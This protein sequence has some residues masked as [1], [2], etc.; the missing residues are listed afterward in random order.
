MGSQ[1]GDD[2]QLNG[3]LACENAEI[4]GELIVAGTP[5]TPGAVADGNYGDVTVSVGGT[6]WT[7]NNGVV[8]LAKMAN[9]AQATVIGRASGAGTGAPTALSQAQLTSL[10]TSMLLAQLAPMGQATIVGRIAG[11]GTGTPTALTATQTG[12]VLSGFGGL[13][14]NVQRFTA[15]GTY[16]PTA[17]T[18]RVIAILQGGGG[19]GAGGSQ[20]ATNASAGG[21]GGSG[22]TLVVFMPDSGSNLT[23]GAVV[24]GAGGAAPAAGLNAGNDGA[25]STIVLNGA[26]QQAGFG[27]GGNAGINSST[28]RPGG[29]GGDLGSAN[30]SSGPAIVLLDSR[31]RPGYAGQVYSGALGG[32][33]GNGGDPVFGQGGR[34]AYAVGGII[35]GSQG[36][37]G[38]GG[39]GGATIAAGADAAGGAG[40][41]GYVAVL[42]FS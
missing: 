18:R 41:S 36:F 17:N 22:G 7:I 37:F 31:A 12:Q 19:S 9:L 40:G 11:G 4:R 29:L 26:T 23:G 42:E 1:Q 34:G 3:D 15:N 39:G 30:A 25:I 13:L 24:V 33:A 20:T 32:V 6:V 5:I 21:G 8:T 27:T 16:T 28:A 38:G 14:L 2:L 35:N 10:I